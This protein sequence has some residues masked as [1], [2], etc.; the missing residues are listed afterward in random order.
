MTVLIVNLFEEIHIHHHEDQVP[1]ID[2]ANV[3]PMRT[4]IVSQHLPCFC[5]EDL[6]E[7]APVHTPVSES[8]KEISC[9]SRFLRC[10]SRLC[11]RKECSLFSSSSFSLHV[12]SRC[13][14]EA[15]NRLRSSWS[16]R[17]CF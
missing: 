11:Q 6:F 12:S 16:G 13:W 17:C 5:R 7:V 2:L 10:N 15:R 1:M 14:P 4:L 8:V 3:G 9:S